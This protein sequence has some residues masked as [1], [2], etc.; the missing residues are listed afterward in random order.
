MPNHSFY[1]VGLLAKKVAA[2]AKIKYIT[3]VFLISRR[4][5]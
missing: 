2:G 1:R 3:L 5:D 4:K